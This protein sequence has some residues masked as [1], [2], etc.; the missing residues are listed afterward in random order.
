MHISQLDDSFCGCV[1]CKLQNDTF[2]PGMLSISLANSLVFAE[3]QT[4]L[5]LIFAGTNSNSNTT[6]KSHDYK[7]RQNRWI[8]TREPSAGQLMLV[9]LRQSCLKSWVPNLNRI[10]FHFKDSSNQTLNRFFLYLTCTLPKSAL[11]CQPSQNPWTV[12]LKGTCSIIAGK[13]RGWGYE[14]HVS[15]G[16]N[17][18]YF[19]FIQDF[20]AWPSLTLLHNLTSPVL[21]GH[22]KTWF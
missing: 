8:D 21:S 1:I 18:D 22:E 10:L 12:G 19:S 16:Y 6:C 14:I 9:W 2:C 4:G 3:P 17:Q 7:E 20:Y 15:V 5:L 11:F 13:D